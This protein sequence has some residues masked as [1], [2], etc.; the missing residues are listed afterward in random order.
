MKKKIYPIADKSSNSSFTRIPS[1]SSCLQDRRFPGVIGD[2]CL[3]KLRFYMASCEDAL[4][5]RQ[6]DAR[7]ARTAPDIQRRM[8]W[9]V[10]S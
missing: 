5:Q 7:N 9:Y 6:R 2:N 10:L 8:C 4:L 1:S 3:F